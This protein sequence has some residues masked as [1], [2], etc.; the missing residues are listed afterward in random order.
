MTCEAEVADLRGRRTR[1]SSE[2]LTDFRRPALDGQIAALAVVKEVL[3]CFLKR[4]D[5]IRSFREKQASAQ[6]G[7]PPIV[8]FSRERG[9]H[10]MPRVTKWQ[11]TS[12]YIR[13]VTFPLSVLIT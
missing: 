6:M 2:G 5:F 8:L 4:N 12:V 11:G 13:F 10:F 1:P 9:G 3:G 7:G